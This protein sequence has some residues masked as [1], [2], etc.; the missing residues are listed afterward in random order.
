MKTYTQTFTYA[1]LCTIT[2]G[3][4]GH[5]SHIAAEDLQDGLSTT[6]NQQVMRKI[7]GPNGNPLVPGDLAGERN[8]PAMTTPQENV[9]LSQPT[10]DSLMTET[11]MDTR[12]A[13]EMVDDAAAETKQLIN[14]ATEKT[15]EFGSDASAKT[16][17]GWNRLREWLRNWWYGTSNPNYT[18]RM[19]AEGFTSRPDGFY[20]TS[21]NNLDD[22]TSGEITTKTVEKITETP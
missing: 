21:A 9:T 6:V 15:K 18:P 14:D 4:I 12:S 19:G 13:G 17:D 7:E 8:T 10:T 1:L 20:R 16:Q 2:L 11:S 22:A 5:T 3:T